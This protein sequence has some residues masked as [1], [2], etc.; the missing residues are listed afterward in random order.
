MYDLHQLGGMMMAGHKPGPHMLGATDWKIAGDDEIGA[1]FGELVKVGGDYVHSFEVRR[2][3]NPKTGFVLSG[4]AV[5]VGLGWGL[6]GEGLGEAFKLLA[7]AYSVAS[8]VK[9]GVA[10]PSGGFG[11]LRHGLFG[12][13]ELGSAQFEKSNWI[14]VSGGFMSATIGADVGMVFL[15]S[16]SWDSIKS[17]IM[18][19]VSSTNIAFDILMNTIAW[20]GLGGF[21]FGLGVEASVSVKEMFMFK[22]KDA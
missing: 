10:L 1:S 15:L 13:K 21:S 17:S 8:H 2:I 11:A 7:K 4:G 20:G 16:R 22:I 5:E 3:S 6:K 9:V 18:S 12:V 19:A 14:Y